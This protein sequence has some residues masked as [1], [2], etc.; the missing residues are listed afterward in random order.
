MRTLAEGTDGVAILST[1]DLNKGFARMLDDMSSYYLLGYNATNT[2]SD[3]RF[4]SITVRVKQPG[5]VV[6]ARKGYRASSPGEVITPP[7]AIPAAAASATP[8]QAALDQLVADPADRAVSRQ[9]RARPRP[10]S[11]AVGGGGASFGH[12]AS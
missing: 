3:G 2:K 5:V 10:D 6:R 9:R 7:A 8:V 4:R 1:N 12:V 11:S